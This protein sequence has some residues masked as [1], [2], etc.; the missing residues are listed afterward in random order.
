MQDKTAETKES[1]RLS[2]GVD[3]ILVR[4]PLR[5]LNDAI[6]QGRFLEGVIV[7][8]MYFERYGTKK[9]ES[10]FKD[11]GIPVEPLRLEDISLSKV[12]SML[13]G[14]GLINHRTHSLMGE[15]CTERNIIVHRIGSPDAIDQ[16]K[17]KAT[18]EKAIEC[19]KALGAT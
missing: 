9:L 2:A 16:D 4:G 5:F 6:A 13:E 11:K 15:V 1:V 12:M 7:S 17:A 3:A 10:Y 14:F 8:V 19:L 18:I